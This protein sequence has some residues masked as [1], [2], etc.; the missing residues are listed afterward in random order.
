M[1]E[2]A[3]DDHHDHIVCTKCGGVTEY[4]DDLIEQRQHQIA[5]EHGFEVSDHVH[6]MYGLCR[7]CQ[8]D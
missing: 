3:D 8:A 6:V 1:F 2:L 4:M 5:A 7:E